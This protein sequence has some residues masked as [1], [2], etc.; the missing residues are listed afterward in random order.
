MNSKSFRL[1]SGALLF[2]AAS[3]AFAAD[4]QT[5][6]PE[7]GAPLQEAQKALQSKD[8]KTAAAKISAAEQV[9]KLTPYE[10][11]I[12]LRLKSAASVGA[13]DYK[14]A[15]SAYDQLLASSE[16]PAAEKLQTLDA[17]V[18]I[19]YASKDYAKTAD[20]IAKYKAAGGTSAETLGLYAQSLYLAGKYKEASSALSAEINEMAAAGKRPTDTQL[21]LL[22]SCALK[23]N[24]MVAYTAALEQL[25]TYSPKKEY[26]LDLLVR[27]QR[28]PGFS[29][30]LDLDMYR[31]REA[32]GTMEKSDDYMEAA[33][34]ALQAGYPGEAQKFVDEGYAAKLLGTGTDAPRHQRLKDL[35]TKK[36]AEDKATLA[37]GEKAAAAQ[38]T[39]DALVNTGFNYVAYGQAD[40]GLPLIEQGIKKGGLKLADQAK[41]HLGVAY[42]MAGKKEQAQKTFSSVQGT[43]GSKDVARLWTLQMKAPAAK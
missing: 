41:L 31:L 11:Y 13:G 29:D 21:Q 38:E 27:T 33:Q 12:V 2:L 25:V 35:V 34:L 37:E 28:K 42:L 9:G 14:G 1:S 30:R 4:K 3:Q 26:W 43:D 36:I 23:Q 8:Y 24:D 6:R 32:T 15:L 5:L 18:K 10:S 7:V 19:A 39:G 20:G 22:A 16:L 17:Y 40:K